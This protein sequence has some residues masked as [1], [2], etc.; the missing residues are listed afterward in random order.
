MSRWT[1]QQEDKSFAGVIFNIIV[2]NDQM[3]VVQMVSLSSS[4]VVF[5]LYP[6]WELS[7]LLEPN[8]ERFN[9]HI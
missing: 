5:N 2:L 8:M 9:S 6:V 3:A 7:D 4:S 1:V